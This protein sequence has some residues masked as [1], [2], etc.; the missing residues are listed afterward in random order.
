MQ[1]SSLYYRAD[2]FFGENILM[3][4]LFIEHFRCSNRLLNF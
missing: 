1:E 2:A 4:L 3:N